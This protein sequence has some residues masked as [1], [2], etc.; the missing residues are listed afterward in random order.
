[1]R[2]VWRVEN[3]VAAVWKRIFWFQGRYKENGLRWNVRKIRICTLHQI[4][5]G[6][7][8]IGKFVVAATC[9]MHERKEISRKGEFIICIVRPLGRARGRVC[10]KHSEFSRTLQKK[11]LIA[12]W[13]ITSGANG[14]KKLILLWNLW[15]VLRWKSR[16]CSVLWRYVDSLVGASTEDVY[17]V[18]LR[19][20]G[21]YLRVQTS[22]YPSFLM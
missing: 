9:S 7:F 1:M 16:Y 22:S 12:T 17:I 8:L 5:I 21:I 19:K 6:F 15:F 10:N 20:V 11:F 4:L 3:R 13:I 2:N 18:F 14:I